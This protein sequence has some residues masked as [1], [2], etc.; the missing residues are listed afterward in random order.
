MGSFVTVTGA[1]Q[2]DRLV[3]AEIVLG[4]FVGAA[5]PLEALSVEGYLD[6]IP[7]APFYAVSGLGHSFDAGAELAPFRESRSVF[8]GPYSGTFDV[9]TGLMLPEAFEPR[10]ALIRRIAAGETSKL[11]RPA[12]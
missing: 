9:A 3:A 4:R 11:L 8:S 7:T 2:G 10:R 12:R 5:G 1:H 6:P